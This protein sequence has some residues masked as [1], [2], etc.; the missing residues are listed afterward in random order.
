[1]EHEA[2]AHA[3]NQSTIIT[4]YAQPKR[5]APTHKKNCNK[6]HTKHERKNVNVKTATHRGEESKKVIPSECG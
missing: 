4:K 1:M 3:N 2:K 5:C 6:R